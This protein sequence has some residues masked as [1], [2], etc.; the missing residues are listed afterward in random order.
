MIKDYVMLTIWQWRIVG[1]FERIFAFE[2]CSNIDAEIKGSIMSIK[3]PIS[4]QIKVDHVD[5]I[6][7]DDPKI[8]QSKIKIIQNDQG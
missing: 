2:L 3:N 6:I 7:M 4:G 1:R 8:D 5:E